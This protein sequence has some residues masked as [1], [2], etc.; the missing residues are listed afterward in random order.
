MQNKSNATVLTA[1][2]ENVTGMEKEL[3]LD[4]TSIQVLEKEA[5]KSLQRKGLEEQLSQQQKLIREYRLVIATNPPVLLVVEEA[6]PA[7]KWDKP[8]I[9]KTL[10]FVAGASIVFGIFLALFLEMG[11]KYA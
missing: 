10:A 2:K 3:M 8:D 7:I 5:V 6:R 1:L 4:D 9:G 11:K